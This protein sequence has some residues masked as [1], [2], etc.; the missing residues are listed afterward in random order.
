MKSEIIIDSWR[1]IKADNATHERILDNI[2]NKVHSD[3][4]KKPMWKVFVPIAA[5]LAVL[6]FGIWIIPRI[7]YR[8]LPEN[9]SMNRPGAE[10]P[11]GYSNPGSMELLPVLPQPVLPPTRQYELTLNKMS[12]QTEPRLFIPG[13]FWHE[14]TVEQLHAILPNGGMNFP[15]SATAHYYGDG[16]LFDVSI[17]EIQPDGNATKFNDVYMRTTIQIS[18]GAIF[19]CALFDYDPIISYVHDV[20]VTAGVFDRS[21]AGHVND[22]ALYIANFELDGIAYRI[23]LND[24]VAG[25][26]GLNRLTEIVNTIIQNGTADLSILNNPVIPELRDERLT[27]DEARAYPGFGTFFPENAPRG[28][29]FDYARRMLNQNFD[30]ILAFWDSGMDSIR[31]QVS[32]PEAHDLAHVVSIYQREKFDLSLYSIPFADS[33][34]QEFSQFVMNPVFL[35]EELTLDAMQARQLYSR[36]RSQMNFSILFDDV[37]VSISVTGMQPE[38]VWEMFLDIK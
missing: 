10:I 17:I 30:G 24:S 14:L 27:L 3:E 20:P 13:H 29:T 4:T 34:P 15:V 9:I 37:V 35:A 5:C 7:G 11:N 32:R 22:I 21:F 18:S 12:S 19:T 26:N 28:F 33:V 23:Q 31:W 2:L 6:L 25:G 8:Y 36:G 1:K 38:Q 16:V